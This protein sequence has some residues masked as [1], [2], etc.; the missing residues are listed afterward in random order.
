MSTS[1]RPRTLQPCS[2]SARTKLAGH[3]HRNTMTRRNVQKGGFRAMRFSLRR[4]PAVRSCMIGTCHTILFVADHPCPHINSRDVN[5]RIGDS[6]CYISNSKMWHQACP[7]LNVSTESRT[8]LLNACMP[9]Y[10]LPMVDEARTYV[11]FAQG[12]VPKLLNNRAY[13]AS[14]LSMRRTCTV[15]LRAC[16]RKTPC[17]LFEN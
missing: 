15:H 11:D 17:E 3:R 16:T 5:L 10:I 7:W 9:S 2:V 8:A 6:L 4:H 12:Q 14:L 1:S 13:S